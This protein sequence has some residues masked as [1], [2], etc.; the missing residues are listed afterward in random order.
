M[1]RPSD[2]AMHEAGHCIMSA[3]YGDRGVRIELGPVGDSAGRFVSA[4]MLPIELY[5][6]MPMAEFRVRE[7]EKRCSVAIAGA[8]A[9]V[10]GTRRRWLPW[11]SSSDLEAFRQGLAL[12]GSGGDLSIALLAHGERVRPLLKR[13]AIWS[14]VIALAT[15]LD[16]EG[17]MESDR[18][19]DFVGDLSVRL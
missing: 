6:V 19:L 14:C 17:N 13:P 10:Q 4:S 2:A 15:A 18:L 1:G 5:D 9:Q 3:I 16:V 11:V 7:G 8:L 12:L